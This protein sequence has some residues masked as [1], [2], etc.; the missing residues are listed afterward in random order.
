VQSPEDARG[1]PGLVFGGLVR[2]YRHRARLT[3]EQLA[4]RARLSPRTVR[5]LERGGVRPRRESVRLLADALGLTG[6]PREEFEA[7]AWDGDWAEWSGLPPGLARLLAGAALCQLPPDLVD[8][9]GRAEQVVLVRDM[10]ADAAPGGPPPAVVVSAVA[11][12]AGVGKTTL[13]VHVAH[14]LRPGFPDGQLYAN[15]RGAGQQPLDPGEVL[16][17][18]LRAL[19]VDGATIPTD[20][21]ERIA[22]YRAWLADRRVLVVLDDA[23]DEAQVRPLLPG[24][25]GCGVLVTS[26]ARLV[27]LE[28]ARLL[29]LDVLPPGQAVE[30]LGRV[31]G[32]ARVAVEPEAAAAIV[33]Y[34]GWLPLAVRI[35]GAKLAGR[36]HWS[37][38]RLAGLLAEERR[39]LDQLTVGDL[40]VRASVALSYQALTGE[41]QRTFRLLGLLA[42]PDFAAWLAAALLGITAE[43]AEVL[44][45]GLVQAQLLE[46]AGRDQTGQVR[47]RFHGLLRL[48]AR[49][50][51]TAEEPPEQQQASLARALGGWLALAEQA[52]QRLP[53]NLFGADHGDA[54][55]WPLSATAVDTLLADPLA[56]LEAERVALVAAVDQAADAGFDE[57][58]WDL[59]GS[60]INFL[61]LRGYLDDWQRT[62][63]A[64]LAAVRRVGNRRGEASLLRGLA[65]FSLDRNRMD[66]AMNYL[67][68]ALRI[69][70]RVGD[71]R[72]EAYA[73]EHIGV[74]HRLQGRHAD[75]AASYQRAMTTFVELGDRHGKAWT[76]FQIAVLHVDQGEL[77]TALAEFEGV[78]VAFR[79]L[80]DRRGETWTQRRLGMAYAA[81]GDLDR[82]AA[83]LERGLAS[84]RQLGDRPVEALT[85]RSLGELYLRRGQPGK[86][87]PL[88]QECLAVADELNDHFVEACVLGSLGDLH[89]LE[90]N[91]HEAACHLERSAELWRKLDMPLELARTLERLGVVYLDAGSPAS[92]ESVWREALTL[93]EQVDALEAGQVAHRLELLERFSSA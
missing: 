60:L 87:R 35:A 80:G 18:F 29:D 8:F 91:H 92:A 65:C 2:V 12:K 55:R 5:A 85:I 24:T 54:A 67:V 57:L 40:E 7:A 11:G 28:G 9:T 30:L 76:R 15:L 69:Y 42:A 93:F 27:G 16:S 4:E 21:G 59:A 33:G 20:L 88:F 84:M 81:R 34:C 6:G 61:G 13:A 56:W 63:Q 82:A 70:R 45:D 44:V 39:R 47:Y 73:V 31:V 1:A 38:E 23:A 41:Q 26:R 62:H 19:G 36:P 75:A 90:A 50:Q 78:I 89:H 17:R 51:A 77:T 32:T 22:L 49:E 58:A 3:Q 53:S 79:E 71:R 66:A 52:D 10:L 72:G 48:Y 25:A 74:V 14:Q 64:G 46:V 37:L 43:Q 86:A 68:Q 83:W